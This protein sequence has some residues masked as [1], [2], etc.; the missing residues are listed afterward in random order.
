L[1]RNARE[2]GVVV[3]PVDVMVSDWLTTLE[4]PLQAR[5]ESRRWD[6]TYTEPLRAV[7]IGMA[8]ISGMRKA[9]AQRIMVARAAA[10]F[11]T[12]EDLAMRAELNA[13]DRRCLLG[14]D[15]LATLA[16]RRRSAV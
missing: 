9:A 13:Q 5:K 7:R 6:N 10:V 2:H 15:A 11:A 3:R 14:A 8:L 1:V 16:G 4:E 12:V